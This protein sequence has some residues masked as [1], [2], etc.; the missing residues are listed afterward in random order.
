[1][2][3]FRVTFILL[4]LSI[5]GCATSPSEIPAADVS[6]LQYKDYDCDDIANELERIARKMN[7]AYMQLDKKASN[8]TAQ[9]AFGILFWPTFFFLEGGDGPQA[10][11][12]SVLKGKFDA[13]EQVSIKKKCGIDFPKPETNNS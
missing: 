6:P 5:A 4:V 13:L 9:A 2:K 12:Y 7:T 8:D 10:A 3:S 11:E 1:M